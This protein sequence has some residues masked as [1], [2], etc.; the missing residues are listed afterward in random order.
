MRDQRMT[1]IMDTRMA[2]NESKTEIRF[3][4]NGEQTDPPRCCQQRLKHP[5]RKELRAWQTDC[6]SE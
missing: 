5:L 2:M 1:A 4:Q 6:D 3:G